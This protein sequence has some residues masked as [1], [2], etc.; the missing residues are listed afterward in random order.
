MKTQTQ[1]QHTYIK[2]GL[3]ILIPAQ[4]SSN[5]LRRRQQN[6]QMSKSW[7]TTNTFKIHHIVTGRRRIFLFVDPS[8]CANSFVPFLS[9]VLLG[10]W[11]LDRDLTKSSVTC[12]ETVETVD[13]WCMFDAPC[14]FRFGWSPSFDFSSLCKGLQVQ[15]ILNRDGQIRFPIHAL[16]HWSLLLFFVVNV[17]NLLE[18]FK[19]HSKT[20]HLA[21]ITHS[22]QVSGLTGLN[23]VARFASSKRGS[24][25]PTAWATWTAQAMPLAG[26][27]K[28]VETGF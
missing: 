26:R 5:Y 23:F 8:S 12:W 20:N 21:N 2:S 18:P 11:P 19:D 6:Q 25:L 9:H 16:H 15:S 24:E 10:L 13:I 14:M 17:W 22:W 7:W 27:N 1:R 28:D 4:H 3:R